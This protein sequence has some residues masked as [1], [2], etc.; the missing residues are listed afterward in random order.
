[1]EIAGNAARDA[2]EV[3]AAANHYLR[4]VGHLVYGYLWAR[5]ARI[6]LDKADSGD[7]FY[8]GKLHTARFYFQRLLPE[9][10]YHFQAARAGAASLMAID[11]SLF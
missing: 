1:M 3:G 4:I 8:V 6:A 5:M 7:T 9:T 10:A 11:E 2:N